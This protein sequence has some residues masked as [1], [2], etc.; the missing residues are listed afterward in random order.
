MPPKSSLTKILAAAGTV[1]AWLPLV[2]P[3]LFSALRFARSGRFLFDYLMP[4]E[5]FLAALLGAGLLVW[6]AS[7]A[8]V[9]GAFGGVAAGDVAAG[10]GAAGDGAAGDGAAGD[11]AAKGAF[12][13][14]VILIS[15][16][17]AVFFLVAGQ[18]LAVVTG[19][20]SGAMT[21]EGIWW[22]LVLASIALYTLALL[23]IAVC[24]ILLCRL[25]FKQ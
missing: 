9:P 3:I 19:L 21:P 12:Y 14:R 15:L 24:G 8:A 17:A 11:G 18:A 7:R 16:A 22:A 23:P 6:A 4:A 13:R 2:T 20:A 5:L 10:D 1:L 25:V